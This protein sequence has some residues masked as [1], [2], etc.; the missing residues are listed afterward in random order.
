MA[1]LQET[2][3]MEYPSI[4]ERVTG[5]DGSHEVA[6]PGP[7]GTK[8]KN[9]GYSTDIVLAFIPQML[10][11]LYEPNFTF[12]TR[13]LPKLSYSIMVFILETTHTTC[14]V[15]LLKNK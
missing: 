1:L 2:M 8:L 5:R 12:L 7:A 4:F 9:I 11:P 14:S 6:P 15:S 3:P 10:A 13:L